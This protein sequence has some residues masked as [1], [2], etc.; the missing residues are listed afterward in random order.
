MLNFL[1]SNRCCI[2]SCIFFK[3]KSGHCLLHLSSFKK[4]DK[5]NIL[6]NMT[7]LNST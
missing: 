6:P 4:F 1:Q 5:C 7:V 3:T 2:Y